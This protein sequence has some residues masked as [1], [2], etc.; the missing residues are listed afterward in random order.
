MHVLR[1]RLPHAAGIRVAVGG[2]ADADGWAPAAWGRRLSHAPKPA[3]NSRCHD[4][5]TVGDHRISWQGS[6][7]CAGLRALWNQP[8]GIHFDQNR[9]LKQCY[10]QDD[11]QRTADQDDDAVY[12]LQ[13]TFADANLV[14]GVKKRKSFRRQRLI[15]SRPQGRNLPGIH[16]SRSR[17]QRP[18]SGSRRV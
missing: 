5:K 10:R 14:A 12:S 6:S 16:W 2:A 9:P 15:K 8:I 13:G 1:Q 17:P 11:S 3:V 7:R 18:R 4:I